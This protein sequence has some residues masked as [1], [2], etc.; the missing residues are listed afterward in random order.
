MLDL[1]KINKKGTDSKIS[2]QS[3]G[4]ITIVSARPHI[5]EGLSTQ[6][7]MNGSLDVKFV[8][9]FFNDII[10]DEDLASSEYVIIDI[11]EYR[12][13]SEIEQKIKFLFPV[14]TKKI[15]VGDV[16]SIS[17]ADEM[18]RIGA[19]YLH[20]DSQ[21]MMLGEVLKKAGDSN[22]TISYTQKISVLGC[23]G[24]SGTSLV[25]WQLFQAFGELSSLP[26]LLIQGHTGTPD[27]DLLS[28]VSLHRDGVITQIN[29][30]QGMKI[31]TDEEQWQFD[32]PDF[33]HYNIVIFDHNVTTQVRDKL[34]YIVPGSDFI[35]IVVTR[36]LSSVRNARLVIDELER[37]S[38]NQDGAKDTSKNI[39]VINENHATKPDELTN[40]DIEN[41]LGKRID[42]IN[43]YA[44]DL[45][46]DKVKSEIYFFA[47]KM[48]GRKVKEDK[49]G[50][51]KKG[52]S[53]PTLF[54][55]K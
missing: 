10:G 13:I 18:K 14:T 22:E 45:K 2:S 6:A 46:K 21:M 20:L 17:F 35:F 27:L 49:S 31:A 28:D 36:E 24:G 7:R 54:R 41:Y 48:L 29:T 15:F 55:K 3:V 40:E 19:T 52:L 5:A 16:D 25:T 4:T 23:K 43:P 34:A 53:L 9:K 42:I 47:A 8:D 33:Q 39:I 50:K 26:I 12:E 11:E 30:H 37:T 44:K 32:A 51:V 38:S 1:T